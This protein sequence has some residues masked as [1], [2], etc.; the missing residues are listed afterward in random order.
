MTISLSI[1]KKNQK[2]NVSDTVSKYLTALENMYTHTEMEGFLYSDSGGILGVSFEGT[3]PASSEEKSLI[4]RVT[5]AG[6]SINTVK[7][8]HQN[9][10]ESREEVLQKIVSLANVESSFIL[11]NH[12]IRY[13]LDRPLKY[14][15]PQIT[16]G[17]M[18]YSSVGAMT[19]FFIKGERH[20]KDYGTD[21][22]GIDY[23]KNT[24]STHIVDIIN[25]YYE[26]FLDKINF[27]EF[28]SH[29]TCGLRHF[30]TA[31]YEEKKKLKITFMQHENYNIANYFFEPDIVF[32]SNQSI[33]RAFRS[34]EYP[35][36]NIKMKNS[37]SLYSIDL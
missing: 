5:I 8:W 27:N 14:R 15:Y 30:T 34:R 12:N 1:I 7:V 35:E 6:R 29:E 4:E 33:L 2:A 16:K 26:S 13:H 25:E 11:I 31:L 17:G 3:L 23:T 19:S 32:C 18:L 28:I 22:R 36:Y 24:N 21:S 9:S 10:K 37:L 20:D